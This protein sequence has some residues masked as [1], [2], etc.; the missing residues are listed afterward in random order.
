MERADGGYCR[1]MHE[2][3]RVCRSA[4]RSAVVMLLA[5]LAPAVA[6]A[7]ALGAADVAHPPRRC[8]GN[9]LAVQRLH[10]AA[11]SNQWSVVLSFR[12]QSSHACSLRGWPR[13]SGETANLHKQTRALDRSYGFR[14]TTVVLPPGASTDAFIVGATD[15]PPS[16]QRSCGPAY[17]YLVLAAPNTAVSKRFSGWVPYAGKYLPACRGLAVSPIVTQATLRRIGYLPR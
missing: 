14:V 7:T 1:R 16:G 3:V 11:E 6:G 9:A 13:V 5:V 15:L 10:S 2:R 12:N 17:R 8:T 4:R